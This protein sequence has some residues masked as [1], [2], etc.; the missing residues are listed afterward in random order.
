MKPEKPTNEQFCGKRP[1]VNNL[2]VFG[3]RAI[4]RKPNNARAG[5]LT[6]LGQEA[7][8][9]GYMK[10]HN[11]FRFL[12]E[13][14]IRQITETCDVRFITG[15]AKDDEKIEQEDEISM[16]LGK[17]NLTEMTDNTNAHDDESETT[18]IGSSASTQ[19]YHTSNEPLGT[20]IAENE[21]DDE[22]LTN[23]PM[24]ERPNTRSYAKSIQNREGP[25]IVG[26]HR[27]TDIQ[28]V[29]LYTLNNEPLTINDARESKDWKHWEQAMKEEISALERNETWTLDCPNGIKP[30][31]NKWVYK[32]KLKP[33]GQI[34]RYKARL[35]AKG[36]TQ[37][38][39][40]DYK[41]T[42]APVASMI[43]VRMFLAIA[44]QNSMHIM[45]FD[46]KTAFLHGDLDEE[47]FMEQPEGFKEGNKICK[48]NK[49]LH[50]LKQAPRQWNEKFD[51]FLKL[52]QLQQASID[53]CLYFNEN[54]TLM[55]AIYVDDGL[56]AGNDKKELKKHNSYRT[57]L[58]IL[59]AKASDPAPVLDKS[60]L[61][62]L[63][64]RAHF[65]TI[66]YDDITQ[67]AY[68][69][70]ATDSLFDEDGFMMPISDWL[71]CT[72]HPIRFQGNPRVDHCGAAAVVIALQLIRMHK[73]SQLDSSTLYA[74]QVMLNRLIN[75]KHKH[76]SAPS[77]GRKS[78]ADW[79][80]FKCEK[81]GY[82]AKNSLV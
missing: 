45:Q 55:L 78:I 25:T 5:K 65:S 17:I 10:L 71:G 58:E 57:D 82:K 22:A 21:S 32:L 30:I 70:D 40:R 6:E 38:E 67:T 43:T 80:P 36:Y 54:R 62:L 18:D 23:R 41:A 49:S 13:E 8:F 19:V 72:I 20:I 37:V 61:I 50:G 68:G 12:L 53:R 14:S 28:D 81:C 76:P 4:I 44:N 69:S 15:T 64:Y 63:L 75:E 77:T 56:A 1:I 34:D 24:H 26:L 31:K 60:K 42:Y 46:V 2:Y 74:P 9:V 33:D 7:T 47:L 11:T 35:V 16:E 27:T 3:Q 51:M 29:A 59:T 48:L 52:F 39:N 79:Q 66:L 73:Q